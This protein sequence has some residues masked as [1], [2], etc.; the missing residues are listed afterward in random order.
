M[1]LQNREYLRFDE[2]AN[3]WKCSQTELF[4]LIATS[5]IIPSRIVDGYY[6]PAIAESLD[7]DEA[8]LQMVDNDRKKL[9]RGACYLNLE[10]RESSISCTFKSFSKVRLPAELDDVYELSQRVELNLD[11]Q[12]V[13]MCPPNILIFVIE[14]IQRA[15]SA[16]IEILA[17]SEKVTYPWGNYST[18]YLEKLSE[19]AIRFWVSCDDP[20]NPQSAPT[21]EQVENW[22]ISQNISKNL[23]QAMATIL[24]ADNLKTGKR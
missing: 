14:E 23:A 6:A 10:N 3:Y 11:S 13:N 18:K 19:A 22:L 24:R 16:C 15:E 17:K 5:K 2:L 1:K 4:D 8:L 21:N 20:T 12:I 9:I 7:G